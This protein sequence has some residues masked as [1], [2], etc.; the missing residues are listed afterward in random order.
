MKPQITTL[1]S[2]F[3][4]IE[5]RKWDWF[6]KDNLLDFHVG[7]DSYKREGLIW[8]DSYDGDI[9]L[10]SLADLLSN[11]SWC[12]AVWGGKH[13]MQGTEQM[14]WEWFSIRAFKLL[15]TDRQACLDYIGGTMV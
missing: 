9:Q 5:G 10:Y 4:R 7:F 1:E 3:K 14:E 6:N 15:Q 11:R 13:K 12:E 8:V 2:I